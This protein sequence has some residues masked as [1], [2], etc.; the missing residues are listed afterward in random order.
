MLHIQ[1]LITFTYDP[2]S[3]IVPGSSR[4]LIIVVIAELLVST[5]AAPSSR[6]ENNVGANVGLDGANADFNPSVNQGTS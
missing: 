5:T 3:T 6:F 4:P 2:P 1:S